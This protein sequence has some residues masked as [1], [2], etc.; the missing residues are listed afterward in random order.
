M[1]GVHS[2][3]ERG[4]HSIDLTSKRV[5]GEMEIDYPD[6]SDYNEKCNDIYVHDKKEEEVKIICKKFLRC[7]EKST[8]WIVKEPGYDVFLLLNY[9]INDK[10]THIFGDK[11]KTD[12]AFAN[13]QR[14]WNSAM[15]YQRS[16]SSDKKYIYEKCKDY[17]PDSVLPTLPCHVQMVVA[18]NDL[19]SQEDTGQGLVDGP[20]PHD[21]DFS[22]HRAASSEA[23]M[24]EVNTDIGIKVGKSILGIAPIALTASA[25]YKFTPMGL[26]IRKLTG[27]NQNITG[28][29]DGEDG[30]L[31]H[32]QDSSNILFN[33]AEN[34]ISYQPI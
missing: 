16:I 3:G 17:N 28:N 15:G 30:F 33:G 32:T 26:W 24:T 6:L 2:P 27:S 20:H 5:Y 29:M 13:F 11:N 23:G 8:V 19:A 10:L 4:T 7:L 14:L 34:Y 22:G 9:W 18:K 21:S 12:V 25:L 31:D 1:A